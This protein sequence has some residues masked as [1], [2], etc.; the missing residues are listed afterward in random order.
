[1]IEF[2]SVVRA[3]IEYSDN[4]R[5]AVLNVVSSYFQVPKINRKICKYSYNF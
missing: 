3:L 2:M 1:M 5:C 4:I